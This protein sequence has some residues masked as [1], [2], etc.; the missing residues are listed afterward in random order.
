MTDFLKRLV[1][2]L[3]GLWLALVL[4]MMALE[5]RLVYPARDPLLHSW[6]PASLD[7]EEFSCRS[8]DGTGV[9]GWV[10]PAPPN[11]TGG[12]PAIVLFHGNAED[13]AEVAPSIGDELRHRFGATVLVFDYR[14][15]GRTAGIP[16]EQRVIADSVA[17][18]RAFADSLA[19]TPDQ[20]VFYGRSLGGG[21]AV[22][23]AAETGAGMLMLDRTF[24]SLPAVGGRAY[25]WIPAGWIMRN[26]FD[27]QRHIA[28]LTIPLFQ[29]HFQEDELIPYEMA[30]QLF[31]A[32]PALQ[33]E[34]LGMPGGGHLGPLPESWWPVAEKFFRQ[35]A[36]PV[37][38][39]FTRPRIV[40]D[41]SPLAGN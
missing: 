25:P 35:H 7:Y 37:A 29:S 38:Q 21:I 40:N 41:S 32:S 17:A 11:P 3:S 27:S 39:R 5:T 18:V 24:N 19:T 6:Q 28:S 30:G 10:L 13:V 31:A 4:I 16:N 8:A 36:P 14:G 1:L 22:Q 15:Y 9:H 26:R 2:S 33:K 12:S 34:F 20:L 23:V